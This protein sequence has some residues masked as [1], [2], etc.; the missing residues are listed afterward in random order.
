MKK[1]ISE[2][3]L[4]F[5]CQM[6]FDEIFKRID[7]YKFD[8]FDDLLQLYRLNSDD[9]LSI[10]NKPED[11]M[12]L[13]FNLLLKNKRVICSYSLDFDSKL[14]NTNLSDEEVFKTIMNPNVFMPFSKQLLKKFSEYGTIYKR[15]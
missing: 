8:T 7:K 2:P 9:E 10:F 15:K 3:N 13:G 5:H 12:T 1:Y 11:E 14:P 6:D 4:L